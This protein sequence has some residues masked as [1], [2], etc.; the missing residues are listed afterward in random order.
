MSGTLSN[1]A[2]QA[3]AY[4]LWQ[5]R[6][7]IGGSPEDDWHR[8]VQM[9][10]EQRAG[11]QEGAPEQAAGQIGSSEGSKATVGVDRAVEESF[12]ASDPPA[13]HV[14]DEPPVNAGAKWQAAK[15]SESKGRPRNAA[16]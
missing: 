15:K 7:G 16:R 13:V 3:L 1:D 6:G 8:A 5:E 10:S 9:L 14:K 4:R 11:S 12:P 2:V